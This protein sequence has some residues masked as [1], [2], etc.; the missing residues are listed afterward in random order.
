MGSLPNFT[1]VQANYLVENADNVASIHIILKTV[2]PMKKKAVN[3]RRLTSWYNY[4][5]VTESRHR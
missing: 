4:K 5:Y 2:A 3:Q 1:P